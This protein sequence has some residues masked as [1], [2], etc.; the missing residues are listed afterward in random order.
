VVDKPPTRKR[1][2]PFG[3]YAVILLILVNQLVILLTYLDILPLYVSVLFPV[4]TGNR[5]ADAYHIFSAFLAF[6]MVVG[7]WRLRHWA[8]VLTMIIVGVDL[9][10][11]LWKYMH[12][13]PDYLDMLINVITVFYLNQGEVQAAFERRRSTPS[14]P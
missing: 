1:R 3:I 10:A 4:G 11:G 5:L 14:P 8:W 6:L 9:A 7:L 12:A 13:T 2:R